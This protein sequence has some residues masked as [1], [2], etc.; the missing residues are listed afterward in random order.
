MKYSAVISELLR[1]EWMIHNP[2]VYYDYVEGLRNRFDLSFDSKYKPEERALDILDS[3]GNPIRSKDG[4]ITVPKNSIAQVNLRGEIV[5]YSDWCVMG[6]DEIVSQLFQAQEMSNVDATVFA[7]NSPGGSTSAADKFKEFGRYKTKPVVGLL[8]D[9]LSLGY[10]AAIE[11]CDYLMLD[12]DFSSRVGSI[13]IVATLRDN[14]KAL[15]AAGVK[16]HE[17]YPP[18]SDFKN[19]EIQDAKKGIMLQ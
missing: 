5:P 16:I 3:Y 17:I 1:G 4:N 7:I 12:G 14:T 19:K 2:E 11:C 10:L 15:E 8:K 6:A 9:A 18:E 13:G